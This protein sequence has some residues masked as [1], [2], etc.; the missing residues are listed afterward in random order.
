MI[1]QGAKKNKL[2]SCFAIRYVLVS[3]SIV[4]TMQFYGQPKK[5]I[6]LLSEIKTAKDTGKLKLYGQLCRA[7]INVGEYELADSTAK[8]TIRFGEN[9][10]IGNANSELGLRCKLSIAKSLSNLAM[11]NDKKGNYTMS[12]EYSS[13]SMGLFNELKNENGKAQC[14]MYMGNS[15]LGQSNYPKALDCFF[16]ALTINESIKNT[17]GISG[18]LGSIGIVYSDREE[19]DKSLEYYFRSLKMDKEADDRSGM[20]AKFSNIGSV[21]FRQKNFPKALQFFSQALKIMEEL[22]NKNGI[23]INVCNLAVT[24]DEM[25]EFDKAIDYYFKG[26]K[27][28][29][30]MGALGDQVNTLVNIGT[31]YAMQKKYE[32]AEEYHTKAKKIAEDIGDLGGM[33]NSYQNLS[34]LFQRQLKW[35][36]AM[37]YYKKYINIRDS[38]FNESNT[39]KSIQSQMNYEYDKKETEVRLFQEKKD[40]VA[41]QEKEKQNIILFSVCGVLALVIGF[42]FF[43]YRSFLQKKSANI[44]IMAQKHQIEA[45]QKEILDSIHYAKRIQTALITSEKYMQKNL[46]KLIK[47]V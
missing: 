45:K 25:G 23:A 47:N 22:E 41:K 42:A 17:S 12:I 35:E 39:R 30:E 20:A 33:E 2:F 36:P 4:I 19:F 1:T 8:E 15:Y 7:Y 14:Y 32:K 5:I 31:F 46:D 11:I 9:L 13:R 26:L 27:L 28:Q 16:K 38:I 37:V 40:A 43:A 6:A 3:L 44:E 24:Y 18:A 29:E 34:D 21:Y 10:S